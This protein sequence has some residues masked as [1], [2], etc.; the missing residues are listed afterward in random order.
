MGA[1]ESVRLAIQVARATG[2]L[3]GDAWEVW[4]DAWLVG[5]DRTAE[6]AVE[7]WGA[8]VS[9]IAAGAA[10]A[11][12]CL[13]LAD[14]SDAQAVASETISDALWHAEQAGKPIDLEQC[15]AAAE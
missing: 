12:C 4:A 13:A 15:K 2:D 5:K 10:R 11:A 3:C 1:R 6:G 9:H 7:A 14:V 8:A